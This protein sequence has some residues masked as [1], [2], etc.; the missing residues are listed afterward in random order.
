M[1]Y[2]RV[3][4]LATAFFYLTAHSSNEKDLLMGQAV[5]KVVKRNFHLDKYLPITDIQQL[6]LSYLGFEEKP[7]LTN[8][9]CNPLS[10][11]WSP[12]GNYF[13]SAYQTAHRIVIWKK[14]ISGKLASFGTLPFDL[15]SKSAAF[16]PDGKY[17]ATGSWESIKLMTFTN[18]LASHQ[19]IVE[20]GTGSFEKINF[21]SDGTLF[22]SH[23][24]SAVQLWQLSNDTQF[25]KIQTINELLLLTMGVI[26]IENEVYFA[27]CSQGKIVRI[28]NYKN[29]QLSLVHQIPVIDEIINIEFSPNGKYLVGT[30]R[31]STALIWEIKN[32]SVELIQTIQESGIAL[33]FLDTE[34]FALA[35]AKH[36]IMVFQKDKTNKFTCIQE[37]KGHT[38]L[39]GSIAFLRNY[40]YL[41][42]G[43]RDGTIRIWQNQA[44]ELRKD[45]N[46]N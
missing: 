42:S 37:L 15:H 8:S 5:A 2:A 33:T 18:Q 3:F 29:G 45:Q 31:N 26:F 25:E 6:V 12:D 10:L 32:N 14:D 9:A 19:Q 35:S 27:I 43:S 17:L 7:I 41:A 4:V 44:V 23:S 1:R 46:T 22:A 13:A 21:S 28:Y 40:E 39:I 20:K 24:G 36:S 34:K 16:S 11:S 30:L 38:E